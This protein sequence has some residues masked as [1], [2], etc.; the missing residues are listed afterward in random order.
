MQVLVARLWLTF[1]NFWTYAKIQD[2]CLI[3]W[4]LVQWSSNEENL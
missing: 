2:M 3:N 4:L 1:V